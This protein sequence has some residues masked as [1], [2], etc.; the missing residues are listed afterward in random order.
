MGNLITYLRETQNNHP[1]GTH[2]AMRHITFTEGFCVIDSSQTGADNDSDNPVGHF[3]IDGAGSRNLS[4]LFTPGLPALRTNERC[5]NATLEIWLQE[6]YE[7]ALVLSLHAL[8]V[9][10][11]RGEANWVNRKSGVPWSTPGLAEGVDYEISAIV[12]DTVGNLRGSPVIS[13][14]LTAWI[15]DA[16]GGIVDN[17]GFIILP[18]GDPDTIQSFYGNGA[19]G[20]IRPRF[21]IET[22]FFEPYAT[23]SDTH[24][25]EA[26]PDTNYGSATLIAA[27]DPFGAG[28]TKHVLISCPLDGLPPAAETQQVLLWIRTQTAMTTFALEIYPVLVTW[29]ENQTTWNDRLSSTPWGAGGLQDGVDYDSTQKVQATITATSNEWFSVDITGLAKQWQGGTLENYGVMI[30][31]TGVSAS[32]KNWYGRESSGGIYASFLE[33]I[34]QL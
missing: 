19:S 16:C 28:N 11:V 18:S 7:N 29:D 24:L 3:S 17:N 12:S 6:P 4:P 33:F 32:T 21:I 1:V 30:K 14:D 22:A 34:Y 27:G 9:D 15:K 20:A 31:Y 8:L 23:D 13:F 10:Y 2:N 26:N 5:I 25:D